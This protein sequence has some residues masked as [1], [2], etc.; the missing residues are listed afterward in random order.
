MEWTGYP[1]DCY[2]Y[3]STCGANKELIVNCSLWYFYIYM[4]KDIYLINNKNYVLVLIAIVTKKCCLIIVLLLLCMALQCNWY[5]KGRIWT[6]L[7]IEKMLVMFQNAWQIGLDANGV[8]LLFICRYLFGC[9]YHFVVI[10][11]VIPKRRGR[12]ND[13]HRSP[14]LAEVPP[15]LADCS[16]KR[17]GT[18]P[19]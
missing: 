17:P 4:I 8:M 11:I 2:D 15:E 14:F 19:P 6:W 16:T 9:C 5:Q 7:T 3:Q 1:L 12:Y 10:F 13:V 18:S